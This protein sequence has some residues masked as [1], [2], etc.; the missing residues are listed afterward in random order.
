MPDIDQRVFTSKSSKL[1][2]QTEQKDIS[3]V[4]SKQKTFFRYDTVERKEEVSVIDSIIMDEKVNFALT[5]HPRM[6]EAKREWDKSNPLTVKLPKT[7]VPLSLSPDTV[8]SLNQTLSTNKSKSS[9]SA[10]TNRTVKDFNI[11]KKTFDAGTQTF[12]GTVDTESFS[13]GIGITYSELTHTG[14]KNESTESGERITDIKEQVTKTDTYEVVNK[15]EKTDNEIKEFKN[16]DVRGVERHHSDVSRHQKQTR[17]L[18]SYRQ[19]AS[20]RDGLLPSYVRGIQV[21]PVNESP[22][23]SL[24][25]SSSDSDKDVY[26]DFVKHGQKNS[27]ATSTPVPKIHRSV[28]LS[29]AIVLHRNTISEGKLS[30]IQ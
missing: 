26:G 10:K 30:E 18:V 17:K 15:N 5:Y 22:D 4:A 11:T 1:S 19:R 21:T 20:S 24:P 25:V 3:N 16:V 7:S 12:G 6:R 8:F 2:S 13:N 28:S 23:M 14:Q 9:Y 27:Y 29:P